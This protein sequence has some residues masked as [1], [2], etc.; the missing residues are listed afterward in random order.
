MKLWREQVRMLREDFLRR[1]LVLFVI[2]R[3]G[4]PG[5]ASAPSWRFPS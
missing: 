3:P 2:F 1:F 4:P 5:R